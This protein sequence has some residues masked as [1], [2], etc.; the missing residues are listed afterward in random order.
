MLV[1]AGSRFLSDAETRYAVIELEMLAVCWA[2]K[3][4]RVFLAGFQH[5]DVATD[6]NPLIPILNTCRL[7]E[8]ENPRLQRLKSRLMAYNFTAQWTK[9]SNHCAADALSRNPVMDSQTGDALAE[10][11][12]QNIPEVSTTEI[13]AITAANSPTDTHL[14][15]LQEQAV[16]DPEY[17]QLQTVIPK[18]PTAASGG[19]QT[20]LECKRTPQC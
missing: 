13:R 4:C 9:G 7:D 10:Y 17:Q 6:H 11:D 8:V 1:Q 3:K 5:F 15:E 20:I 18:S 2:I 16:K 12:N 19:L 14:Q